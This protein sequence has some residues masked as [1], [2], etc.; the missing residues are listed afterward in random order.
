MSADRSAW[1]LGGL[2]SIAG[3]VL[4][5]TTASF[6]A[7]TP[8]SEKVERTLL[9]NKLVIVPDQ[10]GTNADSQRVFYFDVPRRP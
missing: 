9:G 6:T 2:S 10:I 1:W 8:V 3:L 4:L 7:P 5:E